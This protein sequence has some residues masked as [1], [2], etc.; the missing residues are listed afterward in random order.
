[1][2]L[3]N[4]NKEDLGI[5][6]N[7]T[8]IQIEEEFIL[9]KTKNVNSLSSLENFSVFWLANLRSWISFR[10]N[11]WE[12]LFSSQKSIANECEHHT[13]PQFPHNENAT[14]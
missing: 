13:L 2:E 1:M 14:P 7:T 5:T 8:E 3:Y 9:L 12:F 10:K 4:K 11:E 6:Q